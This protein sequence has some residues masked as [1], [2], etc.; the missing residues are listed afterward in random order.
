MRG[1][2]L[3]LF[4]LLICLASPLFTAPAT[5]GPIASLLTCCLVGYTSSVLIRLVRPAG[6][7]ENTISGTGDSHTE[8]TWIVPDS[9]SDQLCNI[10]IDV[11]KVSLFYILSTQDVTVEANNG[12]SPDFTLNL[13]ANEPYFWHTN[14]LDTFKCTADVTAFYISNSSGASATI[15]CDVIQDSTPG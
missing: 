7:L 1:L 11:D 12:T 6:N 8:K 9:T 4:A 3:L 5:A 10:A 14:S 15:S 13:K 2:L